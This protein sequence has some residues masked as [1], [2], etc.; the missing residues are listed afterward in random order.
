MIATLAL[1]SL[2][3]APPS[4][5]ANAEAARAEVPFGPAWQALVGAWT[6]EGDGSPGA[7]AGSA[8]FR[9]ELEG[10]VLVRRSTSDYPAA[11]GRPA[12]HHEDLLVFHSPA[13]GT[14]SADYWDNEGHVIRYAATW[15]ADGKV[16]TLVSDGA[17]GGP[18]YR[19][20]YGFPV[21]NRATVSFEV[22]PPGSDT[23]RKY[24]SGA[25]TKGAR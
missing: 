18:R 3:A 9:F 24:V 21:P 17:G 7:G 5:A 13:G 25:M 15:S 11:E 22:A 8:S 4:P 12:V 14:A 16:L 23:F 19:L 2:L 10:R 1:L 20:V 6:G